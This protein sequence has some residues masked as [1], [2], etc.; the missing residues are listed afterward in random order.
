M[1]TGFGVTS[2]VVMVLAYSLEDRSHRWVAVFAVGCAS[3][4]VYGV[5]TRS[6]VFAALEAIWTLVAMRRF[7]SSLGRDDSATEQ[8]ADAGGG[9]RSL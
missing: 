7:T 9:D 2:A 6:W 1:L 4:A 8:G 3:T 5:L